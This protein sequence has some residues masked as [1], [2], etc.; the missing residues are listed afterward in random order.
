M[1]RQ[2]EFLPLEYANLKLYEKSVVNEESENQ[3]MSFFFK[4]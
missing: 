1:W 4:F 2:R 3:G